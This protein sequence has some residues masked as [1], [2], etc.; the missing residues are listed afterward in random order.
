MGWYG[1]DKS[2]DEFGVDGRGESKDEGQVLAT[3]YGKK[4]A[5]T[6]TGYVNEKKSSGRCSIGADRPSKSLPLMRGRQELELV[7]GGVTA[8]RA[9]D[10]AIYVYSA[11][12]QVGGA[13]KGIESRSGMRE[14]AG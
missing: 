5:A 7:G 4:V 1:N 11:W 9:G 13:G 3:K 14:A 12:E 8:K 6:M 2:T 10:S